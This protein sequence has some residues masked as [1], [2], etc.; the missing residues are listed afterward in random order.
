MWYRCFLLG[1]LQRVVKATVVVIPIMVTQDAGL[2]QISEI[3]ARRVVV[4]Q[5]V[6]QVMNIITRDTIKIYHAPAS[7]Q[8]NAI[9]I[10]NGMVYAN[11]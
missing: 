5:I 4:V 3:V 8:I 7:T 6:S 10:K 1:P 11:R 9:H 2:Y